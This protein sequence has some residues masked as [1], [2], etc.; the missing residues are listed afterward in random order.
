VIKCGQNRVVLTPMNSKMCLN[1]KQFICLHLSS[2]ENCLHMKSS[3]ED[4]K[5]DKKL[6]SD[7][8]VYIYTLH[9]KTNVE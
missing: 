3:Y 2:H 9:M 1:F 4:T 6:S 7:E 8:S 5:K